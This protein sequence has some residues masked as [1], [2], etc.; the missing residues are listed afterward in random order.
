MKCWVDWCTLNLQ[1]DLQDLE[2][3]A[4]ARC[5]KKAC[6]HVLRMHHHQRQKSSYGSVVGGPELPLHTLALCPKAFQRDCDD[7]TC[8][9]IKPFGSLGRPVLSGGL[10]LLSAISIVL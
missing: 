7:C 9:R 10:G 2:C 6:M 5:M 1:F 3:H 4:P 8:T